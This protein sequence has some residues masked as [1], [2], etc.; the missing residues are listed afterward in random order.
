M[1]IKTSPYLQPFELGVPLP[2]GNPHAVS[3]HLPN[4][5]DVI[6]YEEQDP[7]VLKKMQSGYPRFFVNKLVEKL[8]I[9]TRSHHS[10]SESADLLPVMDKKAIELLR[11]RFGS[12]IDFVEL[13]GCCFV[14]V[15]KE[16]NRNK[17]IRDFIRY[18]GLFLSSRKA[19]DNLFSMGKISEIHPEKLLRQGDHF[20]QKELARAYGSAASDDV[21]LASCGMNA[22]FAVFQ[23]FKKTM[24]D[25][26][27]KNIV[28][29]GC[30]YIDSEQMIDENN[31]EE[32]V[33]PIASDLIRLEKI[34]AEKHS[35]VL[36]VFTEVPNNPL[37]D[38]ANIPA[39]S[40]LCRKY[41]IP[42]VVDS[43][44]GTP[45]NMNILPF[46][47]VVVESLTK[48]ACGHGDTIMGAAII[49]SNS[50][51][52]QGI[53]SNINNYLIT[54]YYRDSNRLAVGITDYEKR[55]GIIAQNTHQLIDYLERSP[56]VAKIY[57]CKPGNHNFRLIRK[58]SESLPG[59]ISV[60]FNKEV[61]YY[62]NRLLFAKGPS[63][64]TNFTLL[65]PY[66]YMAH[67]QSLKTK[68]G[69]Q[70]L[71]EMGMN[72]ELLRFSI[73]LEPVDQIISNLQ[74]AGI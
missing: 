27:R 62:Y 23:S 59:L 55:M 63:L 71:A 73:G 34:L 7:A 24:A 16:D 40:S 35:S 39:L 15:K 50:H 25:T 66:V 28:Q 18:S 8:I 47:D 48:F 42:L 1:E 65:M 21:F 9:H 22:I 57:S 37:L 58:T 67:Y 44:F 14:V 45:H 12:G 17:Q 33:I 26:L 11:E 54:P 29:L 68:S 64:G 38:C 74:K 31:S 70:K 32:M 69:R 43:T 20:I 5:D 56:V 41:D 6:G 60:I 61:S 49:N 36:A 72:P 46:C 3:V 13:M 30:L 52:Y 2:L 4:M 10:I 53:K 51:W 19:E